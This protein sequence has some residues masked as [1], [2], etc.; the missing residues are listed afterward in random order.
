MAGRVKQGHAGG[1]FRL[2]LSRTS[3]RLQ[4]ALQ[5]QTL[6]RFLLPRRCPKRRATPQRL[7]P[8]RQFARRLRTID[9]L[10][11]V[12]RQRYRP[13]IQKLQTPLVCPPCQT[14]PRPLFRPRHQLGAQRVAFDVATDGDQMIVLLNRESFEATLVQRSGAAAVVVGV[15]T[16]GMC[17]GQPMQ[18]VRQVTVLVGPEDQMEMVGHEAEGQQ[19]HGQLVLGLAQHAFKGGIV[20]IFMKNRGASHGA[21]EDVVDV[22]AS[23]STWSSWHGPTL[24]QTPTPGKIYESRPL[25]FSPKIRLKR[26]DSMKTVRR[27]L[28]LWTRIA[29]CTP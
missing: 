26:V 19:T 7:T 5:P 20:A 10:Q 2:V 24:R 16:H 6:G 29:I 12:C 17:Q 14:R 22:A 25:F 13:G 4:C 15:P 18:E 3:Q 9:P 1:S 8:R 28:L 21:V 27:G 23:G 11:P